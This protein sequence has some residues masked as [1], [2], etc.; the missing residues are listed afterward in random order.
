MKFGISPFGVWRNFADD[1]AGSNTRGG[2]TNYDH[3][4]ANV[5]KWQKLGWIDYTLPQLYW[6]IGHPLVDFEHLANWWKKH[7]Y[8]RAMYIGHAVYKTD[9]SS[10]VAEWT[11]SAELVRQIRLLRLIPEIGGSAFFSSKQFQ[12]DLYGFQDSLVLDLYKNPALVPPMEWI[13]KDPPKPVL[14]FRKGWGKKVKWKVAEYKNEMDKSRRFV[15]Y[16]NEVNTS[17]DANN[18][19]FLFSVISEEFN[20]FRFQN[21]NSTKKKYEVRISA[22]DRLNNESEVV[23]PLIIKF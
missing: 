9:K 23:G 11:N 3:L 17:F 19:D 12:R 8:N 18:P 5:I 1:P 22:L 7:A 13:D 10:T 20:S 4:F 16:L 21:E 14:N 2:V 15:L 6:H